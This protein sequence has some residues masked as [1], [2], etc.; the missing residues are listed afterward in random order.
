MRERTILVLHMIYTG[1]HLVCT[2]DKIIINHYDTTYRSRLNCKD[3]IVA[4]NENDADNHKSYSRDN[5]QVQQVSN[6]DESHESYEQVTCR[7]SR[8]Q[9]EMAVR[10][11]EHESIL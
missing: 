5:K 6:A 3:I 9:M 4:T 11:F 7:T 1:I 2:P 8:L 10:Q